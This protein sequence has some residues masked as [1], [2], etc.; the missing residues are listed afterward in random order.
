MEFKKEKATPIRVA[1]IMGKMNSGGKKTLA[2]EYFRHMDHDKV[3]FDFICDADSNAIPTDE[4]K[5]L[6]GEVHIVAP[7]QH[8]I[9]N[10]GDMVSLFR[11]NH[12][13]IVH[14]YNSTMNLFPMAAASFAGVPVRI[15]ESVSMGNK[16]EKKYI[17]KCLLRPFSHLFSTHYM[18]CGE[19][20][21]IWQFGEDL[22]NKGK[23]S[24]FKSVVNTEKYKFDPELR[25]TTREKYH[26]S[27]NLVIG[28]IARFTAQK[29]S[30][31][32]ID[33]FHE[34]YELE[35]K[36]KLLLIGDGDLKEAMM[37]KIHLY[38]LEDAVAYLGRRE[39]IL[40]FYNAMDCFLLPSLYEGL[41][42]VGIEAESTGLP[43][44]FSSEIPKESGACDDLS[45]FI[46]LNK[47]AKEWA[48]VVVTSLEGKVSER[49]DHSNEVKA[50]GFDSTEE[51]HKLEAYYS[52]VINAGR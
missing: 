19:T 48:T 22:Y 27:D 43:V 1:V 51:S 40:Q 37:E 52:K 32:L 12:Y 13:D 17:L 16:R 42:V 35:P 21:G 14:A 49:S 6:G 2:M 29:N 26:L 10:M 20:C 50:A 25:K 7:Y 3:K 5:K 28:H 47:S 31:F 30:L 15:N 18:S 33:I 46:G 24:V 45:H 34:I 8:I 38:H 9:Q 11:K 39:D 36:A 44:F 41:P 23:I 4:I